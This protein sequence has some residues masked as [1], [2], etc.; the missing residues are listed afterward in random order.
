MCQFACG[1]CLIGGLSVVSL[2]AFAGCCTVKSNLLLVINCNILHHFIKQGQIKV[3]FMMQILFLTN[4]LSWCIYRL[5]MIKSKFKYNICLFTYSPVHIFHLSQVITYTSPKTITS[6]FN[7]SNF[8]RKTSWCL[9]RSLVLAMW[10]FNC[11][12]RVSQYPK[13]KN[14][15]FSANNALFKISK[16]KTIE[17][18]QQ[19]N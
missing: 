6:R 4:P 14:K 18:I 8:C 9:S 16:P 7:F 5:C 3:G 12:R 1:D 11:L 19:L 15:A 17:I 10:A 13:D 2:Q